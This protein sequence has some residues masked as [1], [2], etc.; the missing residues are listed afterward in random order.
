[1]VLKRTKS[2]IQDLYA[3]TVHGVGT[4]SFG[5][6]GFTSTFDTMRPAQPSGQVLL[7]NP[8]FRIVDWQVVA[9][10]I[11]LPKIYTQGVNFK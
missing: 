4:F 10:I 8:I 1:M 6:F 7:L 3:S 11:H 2:S 9:F 5:S